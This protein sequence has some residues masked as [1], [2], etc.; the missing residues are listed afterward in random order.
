MTNV[1]LAS[2]LL[3]FGI[4]LLL[5][6]VRSM[7]PTPLHLKIGQ[8][9]QPMAFGGGMFANISWIFT[10]HKSSKKQDL[11]LLFQIPDFLDLFSVALSSGE[12]VYSALSRVVPRMT[13]SVANEFENLLT[14][15][16]LGSDFEAELIQMNTRNASNPLG[17]VAN[18]LLQANR[19]GTPL[20]Q[21]LISQAAFV[22]SDLQNQLL[23]LSGRNETRM[24]IPLVFLILPV[25]ILFAIFPSLE[26]LGGTYL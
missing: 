7:A 16:N 24:L 2:L 17:E 10:T 15:L 6:Y 1:Y 19:R 12:S 14:A 22:R 21:M 5:G 26:M 4:T 13:G 9:T 20:A 25:T 11:D 18:R 8:R 3:V 23:K